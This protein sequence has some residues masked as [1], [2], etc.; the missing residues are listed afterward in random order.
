M[1]L[2]IYGLD[3]RL[4]KKMLFTG[5]NLRIDKPNLVVYVLDESGDPIEGADVNILSAGHELDSVTDA[6]GTALTRFMPAINNTLTVSKDG[7]AISTQIIYNETPSTLS[8][9][10]QLYASEIRLKVVNNQNEPIEGATCRVLNAEL[11]LGST[12]DVKAT[13]GVDDYINFG[14]VL[15]LGLD[16]W[17]YELWFKKI[18]SGT[19]QGIIGKYSTTAGVGRWCL[20]EE[21][22]LK[23]YLQT[24]GG[25]KTLSV[26]TPL[27]LNTWVH[28][29]VVFNRA[30]NMIL[31]VNGVSAGSL[32]IA[33]GVANNMQTAHNFVL[34]RLATTYNG[35]WAGGRYSDLRIWKGVRTQQE[36]AD[37]RTKRLAGNEPGLEAYV[38]LMETSGSTVEDIV[39]SYDGTVFGAT[40]VNDQDLPIPEI[41]RPII[42]YDLTPYDTG[43]TNANGLTTLN[44]QIN[45]IHGLEVTLP[46]KRRFIMPFERTTRGLLDWQVMLSDYLATFV[47]DRGNILIN[48]EPENNDSIF[49]LEG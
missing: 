35:Y 27:T 26:A 22:T 21:T 47:T 36:I 40:S 32:S 2:E 49:L 48:S 39:G 8:V 12:K 7:Y 4:A 13:D 34:G 3:L 20:V 37:N 5:V 9:Y 23:V 24:S 6:L 15:D 28:L 1:S 17:T 38:P 25:A 31:Y 29:A 33:D 16:S 19:N 45:T 11:G 43:T 42:G 46:G 18:K 10:V 44:Y 41:R 14:D 30:S